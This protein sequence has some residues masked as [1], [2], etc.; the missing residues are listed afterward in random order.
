MKVGDLVKLKWPNPTSKNPH[1]GVLLKIIQFG[2]VKSRFAEVCLINGHR[3]TYR[4]D[5]LEVHHASRRLSK[6]QR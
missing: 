2:K 1:I 4:M 5:N 6:T 3:A